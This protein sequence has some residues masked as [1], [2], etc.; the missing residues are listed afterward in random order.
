MCSVG[1]AGI[2]GAASSA[3]RSLEVAYALGATFRVNNITI[4]TL[5]YS[6][7]GALGLASPAANT[8]RRYLV[9]HNISILA[10]ANLKCNSAMPRYADTAL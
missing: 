1:Y 7:I 3:S 10:D 6:C 5:P 4:L 9:C 8:V 2:N